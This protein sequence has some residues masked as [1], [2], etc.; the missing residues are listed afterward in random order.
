MDGWRVP[1]NRVPG[2]ATGRYRRAVPAAGENVYLR[3]G[4]PI[5]VQNCIRYDPASG[6]A[7]HL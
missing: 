7:H 5:A 6:D 1:A 2:P 3:A 4:R